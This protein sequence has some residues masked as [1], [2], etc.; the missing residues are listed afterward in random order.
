MRSAVARGTAAQLFMVGLPGPEVDAATAAFLADRAPAG[1]VLF[2]RNVESA[3][4]L[5]RLTDAIHATG[6]GVRPLVAIDHEG[7]RVDRLRPP[8][9]HFPPAAAV[10]ATGDVR[11]AEAVGRAMGRE[12]SPGRFPAPGRTEAGP[13]EGVEPAAPSEEARALRGRPAG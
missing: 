9:T 8:C 2:R 7:G 3:R 13:E 10:G 11:V 4:Q 5:R 12:G 6:A 1:V